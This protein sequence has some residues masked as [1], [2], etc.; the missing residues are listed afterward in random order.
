M[1]RSHCCIASTHGRFN[2]TDVG[3]LP[4]VS[5]RR[6]DACAD[7]QYVHVHTLMG[8]T[9]V[10]RRE[11]PGEL[12]RA[13]V[14]AVPRHSGPV[15]AGL[16]LHSPARPVL[17]VWRAAPQ[18]QCRRHPARRGPRGP[19]WERGTARGRAHQAHQHWHPPVLRRPPRPSPAMHDRDGRD[20][21]L[22]DSQQGRRRAAAK[23]EDG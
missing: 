10:Y 1:R 22:G 9:L 23:G 2:A 21:R 3:A 14:G 16:A 5:P 4:R 20:Q 17:V 12:F 19:R 13:A 11:T 15:A 7:V 18:A 6:L 8:C